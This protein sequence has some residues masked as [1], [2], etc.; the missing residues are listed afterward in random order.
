M[1]W[2][3]SS[4]VMSR[5][6]VG[7]FLGEA[8]FG[9]ILDKTFHLPN[10]IWIHPSIGAEVCVCRAWWV[11]CLVGLVEPPSIG[12]EQLR[13]EKSWK[14][15]QNWYHMTGRTGA[16]SDDINDSGQKVLTTL[17]FIRLRDTLGHSALGEWKAL[18]FIWISPQD[19]SKNRH[20]SLVLLEDLTGSRLSGMDV[21]GKKAYTDWVCKISSLRF[22]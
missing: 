19:W 13:T 2:R 12:S 9:S 18:A 15:N 22:L 11:L 4:P 20:F 7:F 10:F 3:P 21:K 16:H 17:S 14:S 5:S 1:F 8:I 6:K